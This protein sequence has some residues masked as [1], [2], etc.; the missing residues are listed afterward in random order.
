M[1]T[2]LSSALCLLAAICF[3]QDRQRQ[4]ATYSPAETII[5]DLNADKVNDTIVLYET[6]EGGDRDPGKFK[7]MNVSI[8]GRRMT[9]HAKDAWHD[10]DGPFSKA[11]HNTVDSGLAFIYKEENQ[12]YIFLFGFPYPAGRE[13]VFILRVKERNMEIV[14]HNS[15][16]DPQLIAD[17][18]NDGQAELITHAEPEYRADE[19]GS[20]SPYSPYTVYSLYPSFDIDKSLTEKY[21]KEHYV[22]AGAD[23]NKSIEVLHP[24]DGSKPRIIKSN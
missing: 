3:A 24:K 6:P 23:Y 11:S 1:K 19:R 4:N 20:I 5:T 10:I 13:E 17:L 7:K 15:L 22:W 16:A 8:N 12:S 21:N 14:F 9:F 18:D 2:A